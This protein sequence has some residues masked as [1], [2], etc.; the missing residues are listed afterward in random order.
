MK[1]I[2][3]LKLFITSFLI[4]ASNVI[5]DQTVKFPADSLVEFSK[6]YLG[7]PYH[8]GSCNPKVGF[9]CSGFV[10]FVFNHFKIKT[11]RSSIDFNN[12]GKQ[13]EI[14]SCRAGDIIVFTGT[15]AKNRKPGHVGIIISKY[16]EALQFIHS[17][18]NKKN[19]GVKLST[20]TESPY[21]RVRFIKIVR[22][23]ETR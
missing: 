19:G 4:N 10:Y 6:L 5:T 23:I 8:H 2:F 9:D 15:N 11:P 14:D 13:I 3:I 22:I 21:Y 1:H 20:F 17:S 7:S 16:G 18:S 12:Y